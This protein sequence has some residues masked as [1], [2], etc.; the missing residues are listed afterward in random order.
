MSEEEL[1]LI[2]DKLILRLSSPEGKEDLRKAE[3]S[4]KKWMKEME[5]R[6]K[7]DPLFFLKRVTPMRS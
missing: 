7:R 2:I 4:T 5:V 3:E 1:K 6:S